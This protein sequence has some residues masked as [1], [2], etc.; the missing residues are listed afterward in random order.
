MSQIPIYL[1]KHT[2]EFVI[3][4]SNPGESIASASARL[5]RDMA[6]GCI[7]CPCRI[8]MIEQENYGDNKVENG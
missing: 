7:E 5:L 4:K 3:S 8:G 6:L 2:T 1:N